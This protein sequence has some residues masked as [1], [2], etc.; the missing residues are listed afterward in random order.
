MNQQWSEEETNILLAIWS[1]REIQDKLEN[2]QR[3]AKVYEEVQAELLIAGYNRT[4][5]QITNKLKKLKKDYRDHKKEVFKG[6]AGRSSRGRNAVHFDVLESVLGPRPA[7][8]RTG[9]LNSTTAVRK[10]MRDAAT[11]TPDLDISAHFRDS[12]ASCS[13]VHPAESTA[14]TS[15]ERA[16]RIRAGKRKMEHH[17]ELLDYLERADERFLEHSRE[18]N[19]AVLK[20]M[21]ESTNALLGLMG[22]MVAVMEGQKQENTA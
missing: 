18:L 8:Q 15:P 22:R 19:M 14:S 12:K 16:S 17:Q 20:K 4:P 2:S 7:N 10:Q 21:D 13:S 5:E 9:A 6:G 1:S 3:K 11:N